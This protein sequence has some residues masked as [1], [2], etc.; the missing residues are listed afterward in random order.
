MNTCKESVQRETL[1]IHQTLT[2]QYTPSKRLYNV[3]QERCQA[4]HLSLFRQSY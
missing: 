1:T 4:I 2:N 3:K